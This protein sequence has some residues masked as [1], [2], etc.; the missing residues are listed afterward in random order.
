VRK[1]IVLVVSAISI[2]LTVAA[3]GG[4]SARAGGNGP[5]RDGGR[6]VWFVR[7]C[8]APSTRFGAC[9]AQV[10]TNSAGKPLV[11]SAAPPPNAYGPA[12]FHT[13]YHLPTL[14]PSFQTIAIVDA[15]DDPTIE[16]DLGTFSA[17]YG[18][19]ACTTANGCFKKVN[20]TGGTTYPVANANWSLEISLDVETAH[21]MCQNCRIL[22][23]E[24][25]SASLAS[26]GTAENEAVALGA[27]VISNSWGAFEYSSET[28]DEA[29]Y[30]NHPG[31]AITASTGDDGYGVQFP[32]SSRYVTAVGG[33]TL[34]LNPDNTWKSESAWSGSG[35]GCSGLI[36]KPVWQT[37]KLCTHRTVADVAADADPNTGAAVYDSVPYSGQSGW[38]QVGGTSLAA[39][40]IASVY[41]L[42]GSAGSVNAGSAPY[43]NPAA[44][45][46]V[47]SGSNGG[48]GGNYLC[49]AGPGYDGPTGLGTPNGL[50]AFSGSGGGSPPPPPP[51]SDFSV[52]LSPS[53]WTVTA[54]QNAVYTVNVGITGSFSGT[55]TFSASGLPNAVFAPASVTGG[56]SST[57]T[58]GTTG[59]SPGT[60]PFTVTG[61][62]GQT[63]HSA[64]GTLVVQAAQGPPPPAQG[65]FSISVSP[66][67]RSILP[68]STT[69]YTVTIT[70]SN[71]FGGAVA[72]SA[73]GFPGGISGS[74][75]PSSTTSTSTFTVTANNASAGRF[76]ARATLTITGTSGSLSHSTTLVLIVSGSGR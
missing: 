55:V 5:I 48:C 58:V 75:S 3:S 46:D 15:Y 63:T 31:V 38:F 68:T 44:L 61:T 14:A 7:A 16:A 56:G 76:G 59:V 72:L 50:A 65:D 53:S 11:T 28:I 9:G 29:R 22:L 37:D 32:A 33:T 25:S 42:S 27:N 70:P 54:G 6:G 18:L 24:A 71:G 4:P 19:P 73:T 52:G 66:S 8:G 12:Q 21:A 35:S 57:L 13:A 47:T 26:L 67:S 1:S 23:V 45:H 30:F 74:F 40:L 34:T 69:T 10:V 39:P 60:Y 2:A 49:T 17:N 41:A 64:S 62:S 43:A 51:P 20:Q 36:P